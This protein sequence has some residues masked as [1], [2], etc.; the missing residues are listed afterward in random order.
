MKEK[1]KDNNLY[2]RRPWWGLWIFL[3]IGSLIMFPIT[4]SINAE[5]NRLGRHWE[6]MSNMEMTVLYIISVLFAG[7]ICYI[8]RNG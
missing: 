8:K 2:K 7:A 6:I 1:V 3:S 4:Y 5:M